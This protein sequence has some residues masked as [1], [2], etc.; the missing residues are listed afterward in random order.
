MTAEWRSQLHEALDVEDSPE[1]T[2]FAASLRDFDELERLALIVRRL[3][4]P[5]QVDEV[6]DLVE[7]PG[8]ER[9]YHRLLVLSVTPPSEDHGTFEAA[10]VAKPKGR[11]VRYLTTLRDY[12]AKGETERFWFFKDGELWSAPMHGDGTPVVEIDDVPAFVRALA[13]ALIEDA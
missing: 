12:A 7:M 6:G 1:H 3:V 13:D 9:L 2:S 5:E 10:G 8:G 11:D 4:P